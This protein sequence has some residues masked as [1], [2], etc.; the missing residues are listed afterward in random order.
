M[1]GQ[2]QTS[3][4]LE[5]VSSVYGSLARVGELNTLKSWQGQQ[6]AGGRWW[7]MV[8]LL[9]QVSRVL[10]D[11]PIRKYFC[12][13]FLPKSPDHWT[14]SP[15]SCVVFILCSSGVECKAQSRVQS[16]LGWG[17]QGVQLFPSPSGVIL[18]MVSLILTWSP[19]LERMVYLVSQIPDCRISFFSIC[20]ISFNRD[21][22]EKGNHINVVDK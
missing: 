5:D 15:R 16:S 11:W 4:N 3:S 6:L 10:W 2:L 19:H 1:E 21:G 18:N 9:A 12:K 7:Q 14:R 17:I 22:Q 8:S 13:C 20:V